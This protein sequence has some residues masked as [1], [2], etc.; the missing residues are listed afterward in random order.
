[1]EIVRIAVTACLFVLSDKLYMR[2]LIFFVFFLTLISS[3]SSV[4]K[5]K[6]KPMSTMVED[7][8]SLIRVLA[9]FS[10]FPPNVDRHGE[11][12]MLFFPLLIF[13]IF[14]QKATDED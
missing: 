9:N 4:G 6:C 13:L 7:R 1:M 3:L 11:A 2:K 5:W 12:G 14:F 8:F 10:H